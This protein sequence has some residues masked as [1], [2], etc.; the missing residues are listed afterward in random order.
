MLRQLAAN[1]VAEL[2]AE[3]SQNGVALASTE[4]AHLVQGSLCSCRAPSQ[5]DMQT[6]EPHQADCLGCARE[7][8][9]FEI[10]EVWA[11]VAGG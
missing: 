5:A 1:E 4:L 2:D 11:V 7:R 6:V 8:L 3:R 9:K 10:V